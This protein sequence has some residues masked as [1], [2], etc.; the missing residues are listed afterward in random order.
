MTLASVGRTI[1]DLRLFTAVRESAYVYPIVLSTHVACIAVFGGLILLTN[2]RLLEWSLTD[3]PVGEMI[4][5]FRPWK[6]L[7]FVLMA[8]C[9]GLL[10]ASKAAEYFVNPFFQIKLTLLGAIG[11]HGVYF[12]RV[13]RSAGAAIPRGRATAA[14]VLSLAL[15]AAVVSMGRWIAYYDAP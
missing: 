1:Q 12:R 4:E 13:Y 15:W 6:Q 5:R 3:V 9:G 8:G 7:G 14:A 11:V 2:L 10:A